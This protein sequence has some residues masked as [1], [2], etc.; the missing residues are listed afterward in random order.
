MN[1]C[2]A[3]T[4]EPVRRLWQAVI[5]RA[6]LDAASPMDAIHEP[7]RAWLQGEHCAALCELL[8]LNYRRISA[9][10]AA[11]VPDGCEGA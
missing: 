4:W 1:P 9:P 10:L 6:A 11:G 2:V 3:V 7:A 5:V 8:D